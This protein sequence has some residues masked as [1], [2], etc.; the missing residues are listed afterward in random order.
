MWEPQEPSQNVCCICSCGLQEVGR[1]IEVR[2]TGVGGREQTWPF[3]DACWEFHNTSSRLDLDVW[4]RQ[5]VRVH[6]TKLF[7]DVFEDAPE[8]EAPAVDIK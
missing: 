8:D 3:C 4:R 1:Q 7:F 5:D 2:P 6:F